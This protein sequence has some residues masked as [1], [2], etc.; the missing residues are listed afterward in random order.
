MTA[1]DY[2]RQ[3]DRHENRTPTLMEN[4]NS[5]DLGDSDIRSG[6][7]EMSGESRVYDNADVGCD[8]AMP[9]CIAGTGPAPRRRQNPGRV[10]RETNQVIDVTRS[11]ELEH[12]LGSAVG[13]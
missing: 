5:Q 10:V 12:C 9:D 11:Q 2:G 8:A 4:R 1:L 6:E 7:F 3:I 13:A